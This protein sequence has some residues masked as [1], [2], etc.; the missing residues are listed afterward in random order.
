[1]NARVL[2]TG[3]NGFIGR[4][5]INAYLNSGTKAEIH[6]VRS[7]YGHLVS[8]SST[9]CIWHTIDLLDS[10]AVNSLLFAIKPTHIIHAAWITTHGVYWTSEENKRWLEAS[11]G[12]LDA[13]IRIGG[14]RFVQLGTCAEYDWSEGKLIEGIT[15]EKPATY[16]GQCK[17]AFHQALLE[18]IKQNMISAANGRVFFAYGP[19]ENPSRLVPSVCRALIEEKRADFDCGSLWRDYMHVADLATAIV[20]LAASN[21]NGAVNLGTGEPIRLSTMLEQLGKISKRPELLHLRDQPAKSTNPPI[22]IAD[23]RRIRSIG[24]MPSI[25]IGDGL[26]DTY[27]WWHSRH[28]SNTTY[29][30]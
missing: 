26:F 4:H 21:L 12:L 16:Y 14:R 3:A 5:V 17:L 9:K 11:I 29:Q 10:D 1:M 8:Q 6:A 2:V 27:R 28:C 15:P 18:R 7:P 13:F 23:T 20:C 22:L 25:D 24:W 19:Y 30:N